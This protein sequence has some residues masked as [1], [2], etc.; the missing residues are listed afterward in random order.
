MNILGVQQELFGAIASGNIPLIELLIR[1]GAEVNFRANDL[2]RET[3]LL[4]AIT[5]GELPV[6]QTLIEAGANV[7]AAGT[8]TGLTG[9]MRS[10]QKPQIMRELISRGADV[11]A[12]AHAHFKAPTEFAEPTG[13]TAL[14][15]A[16]AANN[17]EAIEILA[18]SGADLEA[19]DENG[20]TPL[21]LAIK[22]GA[23]TRAALALMA[24]GAAVTP[25][26]RRLMHSA[27]GEPESYLKSEDLKP[28][29]AALLNRVSL[30]KQFQ[31]RPRP[32][33]KWQLFLYFIMA[34]SAYAIAGHAFAGFGAVEYKALVPIALVFT[35]GIYT[36]RKNSNPN[37]PG[38]R[39]NVRR[40][41][42]IFCHACGN[43]RR[44]DGTCDSCGS[45]WPDSLFWRHARAQD[46]QKISYCPHCG[47]WLD[48]GIYRFR[49]RRVLF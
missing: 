27:A 18:T 32:A 21:D 12:Q 13:K 33:F 24:A 46:L 31:D 5:I 19:L 42:P 1:D 10:I 36:S 41:T 26:R 8:L 23:T 25:E 35:F 47:V 16:A 15:M 11:N 22:G 17:A 29:V 6:V 45:S 20:Q 49:R 44:S 38:C 3:P 7:N 43:R 37:C 4:R 2:D 14:H 48:T 40:C 39:A 9:L 30:A 34:A 28:E